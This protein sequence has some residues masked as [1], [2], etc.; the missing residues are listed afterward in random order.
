MFTGL[1]AFP[2]TPITASGVDEQGFSNGVLGLTDTDCLPRPLQPLS[3][4][5]IADIARVIS[6]LEL[7]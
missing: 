3:A 1:S 6:A 7:K 5:D 2:L 4:S